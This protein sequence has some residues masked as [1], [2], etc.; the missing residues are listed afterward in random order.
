MRISGEVRALREPSN[1]SRNIENPTPVTNKALRVRCLI[2][3]G[4]NQ[5]FLVA[6]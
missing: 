2:S 1:G 3:A 4:L 5:N 6:A